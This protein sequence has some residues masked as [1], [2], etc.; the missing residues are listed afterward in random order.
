MNVRA[1]RVCRWMALGV[2]V[3]MTVSMVDG[4]KKSPEEIAKEE[5]A[6]AEAVDKAFATIE[7]TGAAGKTEEA[8]ALVEKGLKEKKFKSHADRFLTKKVELLLGL[9][10]HTETFAIV[11]NTRKTR[12]ALVSALAD[13]IQRDLQS[14][15]K[16]DELLKW[17]RELT[18]SPE[19]L[20]PHQRIDYTF[21]GLDA[22]M[23]LKSA[24]EVQRS[25]AALSGIAPAKDFQ[26]KLEQLVTRS[27]EKIDSAFVLEQ[28]DKQI[29]STADTPFR[30]LLLRLKL[31]G[32]IATKAWPAAAETFDACIAQMDDDA[33]LRVSRPFYQTLRKSDNGAMAEA[34]AAKVIRQ[35][36]E[37]KKAANLAARV[38]VDA[39]VR[40]KPDELP[41]RL[42]QL[43]ADK[44]DPNQVGGL[45]DQYFY[46]NIENK[47]LIKNLCEVGRQLIPIC[48][49]TNTVNAIKVKILDGA[50]IT[51]NYAVAV[52]MLEKGIPG[53]DKKWHDMSIPKVKAHLALQQKNPREAVKCF[54]TFM[55]VWRGLDQEEEFDPSTGIAYSK[56]WILGRNA[57]RIATILDSIPDKEEADKA[58]AE[59][60]AYYQKA[61]EKAA[62]DEAALKL[63]K[64]ETKA[65]G[66]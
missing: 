60:K 6:I 14:K 18:A 29:Q 16:Y 3:V 46:G 1:K 21:W 7:E 59:A 52:E 38:W 53:K 45:F 9:D 62:K 49:E 13:Q 12:P 39:G 20:S 19:A 22:A 24:E 27:I 56:E 36:P 54:R 35:V 41:G 25:L 40:A 63:L 32:Q 55:D 5:A 30:M 43:L 66:L 44:I 10:R 26:Q 48:S 28:L 57:D 42:T 61:L 11:A 64:Q 58:R 8:L 23:N 31:Q 51:E 4:C 47:E 65:Y 15:K 34:A 17:S 2:L 37:K 50:F 33:L